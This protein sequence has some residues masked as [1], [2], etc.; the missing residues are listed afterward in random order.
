MTAQTDDQKQTVYLQKIT[1]K[2]ALNQR[3]SK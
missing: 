2:N 3:T 1:D